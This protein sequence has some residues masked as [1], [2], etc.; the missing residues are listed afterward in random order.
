MHNDILD[1]YSPERTQIEVKEL[2]SECYGEIQ[3]PD[4]LVE[5]MKE[6]VLSRHQSRER[7]SKIDSVKQHYFS[8]KQSKQQTP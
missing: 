6:L 2:E 8:Q 3:N 4:T 1:H 7:V 5:K